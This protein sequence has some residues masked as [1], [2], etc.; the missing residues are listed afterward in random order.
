MLHQ[1]TLANTVIFA[2]VA[3]SDVS[4][5]LQDDRK[6]VDANGAEIR[7]AEPVRVEIT[8]AEPVQVKNGRVQTTVEEISPV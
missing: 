2:E 8:R 7:R 6:C 1:A 4:G 3:L 5:Y